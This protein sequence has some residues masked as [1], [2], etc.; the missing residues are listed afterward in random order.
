MQHVIEQLRR[1]LPPVFLG[2][3]LDKLT[4]NAIRW[5]TIQNRRSRREIPDECFFRSG[6]RILVLRD[7]FLHWWET[8]LSGAREALGSAQTGGA[9][10]R[11]R[12]GGA[13]ERR[14][15]G[16]AA[17]REEHP[18]HPSGATQATL[19]LA[20]TSASRIPGKESDEYDAR[21]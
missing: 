14:R 9:V 13:V 12:I 1:D 7:K 3:S 16:I 21:T 5:R 2:S 19:E 18:P 4:G 15:T 10:V 11:Q 17:A 20:P 6:T 8:T